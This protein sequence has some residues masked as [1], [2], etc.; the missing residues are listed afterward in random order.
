MRS[1]ADLKKEIE[2]RL[3]NYLSRD[4]DGIRREL[5]NIFVR[6]KS[7]TVEDT[8]NKLKERFAIS[9]QSV[10]SMIGIIASK[11][12]ILHIIKSRDNDQTRYVLKDQYA[13]LV[14]RVVDIST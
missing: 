14:A 6:V 10:A 13:D 2:K 8:H 5:L 12:G 4:K 3:K 9:Y 11:M 1:A 7:V